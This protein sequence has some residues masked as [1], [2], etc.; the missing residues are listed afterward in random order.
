MIVKCAIDWLMGK[1]FVDF[2]TEQG[3]PWVI[4]SHIWI[5]RYIWRNWTGLPASLSVLPL[6]WHKVGLCVIIFPPTV[7]RHPALPFCSVCV[8]S[9][10]L[11]LQS[12][13]LS[14]IT[15]CTDKADQ[16]EV[17]SSFKV[18]YTV[19]AKHWSHI[20]FEVSSWSAFCQIWPALCS[21]LML[22]NFS[23]I[24]IC[25][26]HSLKCYIVSSEHGLQTL[27][28]PWHGIWSLEMRLLMVNQPAFLHVPG[29]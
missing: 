28:P 20:I 21:Y 3:L 9:H 27:L 25:S 4:H 11:S 13:L 14:P 26:C 15:S 10:P 1:G 19:S 8:L 7:Y 12:C 16:S 5:L 17:A 29:F 6:C 18:C 22:G 2:G 23:S 24:L